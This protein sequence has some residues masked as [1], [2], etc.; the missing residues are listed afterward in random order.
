MS[1]RDE[2]QMFGPFSRLHMNVI[3]KFLMRQVMLFYKIYHKFPSIIASASRTSES[4]SGRN[5]MSIRIRSLIDRNSSQDNPIGVSNS[6]LIVE[7]AM[8]MMIVRALLQFLNSSTPEM[9]CI[10]HHKSSCK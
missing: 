3:I 6:F 4:L 10:I 5:S 8:M 7:R 9:N 1:Q 2:T